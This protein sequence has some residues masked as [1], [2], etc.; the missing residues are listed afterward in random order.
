MLPGLCHIEGLWS[1]AA[2]TGRSLSVFFSFSAD[3]GR[4]ALGDVGG[5]R[6]IQ[7]TGAGGCSGCGIA[8]FCCVGCVPGWGGCVVGLGSGVGS[9]VGCG[10]WVGC[11]VGLG[12]GVGSAAGCMGGCTAAW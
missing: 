3:S 12:S 1:S 11:V 6:V 9:A 8:G 2:L 4:S 10:G 5:S 7:T